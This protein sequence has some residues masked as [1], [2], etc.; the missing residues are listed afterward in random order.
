[1][2]AHMS[3][4]VKIEFKMVGDSHE[5]EVEGLG[6]IIKEGDSI[7]LIMAPRIHDIKICIDDILDAHKKITEHFGGE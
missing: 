7:Q 4:R 5:L 1:M 3:N 2:G 6:R